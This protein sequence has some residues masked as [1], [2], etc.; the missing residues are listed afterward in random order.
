MRKEWIKISSLRGMSRM[1]R[2]RTQLLATVEHREESRELKSRKA[3]LFDRKSKG[4]KMSIKNKENSIWTETVYNMK[5][6]INDQF[7]RNIVKELYYS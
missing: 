5:P 3:I 6:R 4:G 1:G 7:A 2:H